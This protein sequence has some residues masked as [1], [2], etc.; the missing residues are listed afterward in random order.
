MCNISSPKDWNSYYN[1]QRSIS[2]NNDLFAA[3]EMDYPRD[4]EFSFDRCTFFSILRYA[5][6]KILEGYPPKDQ[7]H[8]QQQ[9]GDD[10]GAAGG[11]GDSPR[12]MYTKRQYSVTTNAI[13]DV[14]TVYLKV[15]YHVHLSR[16][17]ANFPTFIVDTL[18]EF[19]GQMEGGHGDNGF[20]GKSVNFSFTA[21]PVY[22][23]CNKFTFLS[24]N[25]IRH[26]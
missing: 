20:D 2:G 18:T 3:S 1:I 14:P 15:F 24:I 22:G 8:P 26:D 17:I 16:S 6:G 23:L 19:K 13:P 12:A 10:G 11:D 21:V 4:E 5:L 9:N 7:V 25:G